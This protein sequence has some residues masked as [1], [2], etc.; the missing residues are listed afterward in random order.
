VTRYDVV[1]LGAGMSAG[2][3]AGARLLMLYESLCQSSPGGIMG[4]RVVALPVALA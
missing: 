3:A 4:S 1:V 2:V